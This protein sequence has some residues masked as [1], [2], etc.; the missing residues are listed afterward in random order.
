MRHFDTNVT[1][2]PSRGSMLPLGIIALVWVGWNIRLIFS[3]PSHFHDSPKN[4]FC[5]FVAS[6]FFIL[7]VSGILFSFFPPTSPAPLWNFSGIWY[8][9]NTFVSGTMHKTR[10]SQ[11]EKCPKS[12]P[13]KITCFRQTQIGNR[14]LLFDANCFGTLCLS[15]DSI[16]ILPF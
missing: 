5:R 2:T 13:I 16:G 3:E 9:V 6:S 7:I 10:G 1:D 15:C 12:T 14:P 8:H 11:R 4:F